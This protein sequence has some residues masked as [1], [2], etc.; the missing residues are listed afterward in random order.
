MKTIDPSLARILNA[1][2]ITELNEVQKLAE[3]AGLYNKKGDFAL[4]SQS[5][6]G[7]TFAGLLFAANTMYQS[8][9]STK[10]DDTSLSIFIAPF[11]ASARETTSMIS[12]YFGWFLRPLVLFRGVDESDIVIRLSKGAPP[13]IIVATPDAFLEFIR[14]E[15]TRNWLLSRNIVST[16]FDDVHS[17]LH[18]PKRGLR[19]LEV[20]EFLRSI[21][22]SPPRRL[23]LS[24][25]FEEP[26]RLESY[27]GVKL[28]LDER[29]YEPPEITMT[30]YSKAKEKADDLLS[31]LQ[32]LADDG[33]RTLVYMK[34][35]DNINSF[36]EKEGSGLGTA[37]SFDIDHLIKER[38][39]RVS[40]IIGAIG[41]PQAKLLSDGIGVYHGILSNAQRWFIEWLIRRGYLRFIFGTE[42][43]AYG[44]TAPVSHVVME[45]PGMDE[46]FRQSMMARAVRLRR[47]RIRPGA[48]TV[49]T[50]TIE[51]ASELRRVYNS[52][53][54]PIRF[55]DESNLS[56][57]VIGM[58]GHG[59]L[60]N[61]TDRAS[62]SSALDAFFK[63]GSTTALIKKMMQG[64]QPFISKNGSGQFI[65]T[66]LGQL[67]FQSGISYNAAQLI[68]DGL[69]IL[70]SSKQAPNDMDVLLLM[71]YTL[72]QLEYSKSDEVPLAQDV[73]DEY[74]RT[75]SSSLTC[76]IIDTDLEASWRK[77][78]EYSIL[79]KSNSLDT[80]I[81]LTTKKSRDRLRVELRMLFTSF[82]SFID[83]LLR[84]LPI[85]GLATEDSLEALLR[86]ASSDSIRNLLLEGYE[87]GDEKLKFKDLSFVD[88]GQIEKSIDE[89]LLSNLTP[90]QKTRLIELLETV[91]HTTSSFVSLLERSK[92]SKEARE[93]LDLV[94]QF[95]R[96]GMVGRNLVKALEEEGIMERGTIDGLWHRFSSEVEEIQKR[97]DAPAKAASVLFSLF[98]GDIV[99]L[100]TSSVDAL[101]VAFGR[102]RKVDTSKIS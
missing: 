34:S 86:I 47:G 65:L 98:T 58:I 62:L 72:S 96:E 54:L 84:N 8:I 37:V 87:W 40:G 68:I 51:D 38:L 18:D 61:D 77:A 32:D 76:S 88:F 21:P 20:S 50:K 29:S 24:A 5:R 63:K 93:T 6:T 19:L 22:S 43:L 41:Y 83:G 35:I 26:E 101:K 25:E 60:R 17:I 49:F 99:G 97:T 90:L 67:A 94:C 36:L 27:F 55:I 30:R 42:A 10:T 74:L 7:K 69:N 75:H 73:Q 79:V 100:A 59:L 11:H 64:T 91:Q 57:L 39:S 81:P 2:G 23:V 102:T 33:I 89:A 85:A 15:T 4:M 44:I 14:Y 78:I 13:N 53:R 95:S 56:N 45:S 12:R 92:D 46:V 28:I 3:K 48:C 16:V 52:P 82:T 9:C 31:L 71:N 70:Q 80:K 66:S 1:L